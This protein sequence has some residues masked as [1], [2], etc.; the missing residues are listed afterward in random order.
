[1]IST[2]EKPKRFVDRVIYW[3]H[4]SAAASSLENVSWSKVP[5]PDAGSYPF[6]AA[7]PLLLPLVTSRNAAWFWY[8]NGF[9]K[10]MGGRPALSRAS[11]IREIMP[12]RAGA[13]ADVPPIGV[14]EP[15]W[16]M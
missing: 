16:I 2:P 4:C 11:L 9:K 14:S 8:R 13:A 15:S 5:R 6:T 1:M 3:S 7:N 12:A 10:P